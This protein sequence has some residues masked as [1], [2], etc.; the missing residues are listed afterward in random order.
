MGKT[1]KPEGSGL[2]EEQEST[3][4]EG[5]H[6]TEALR[7]IP[8][9]QGKGKGS[10]TILSLIDERESDHCGQGA[11]LLEAA[12]RGTLLG[13]VGLSEWQLGCGG[14]DSEAGVYK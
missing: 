13:A 12:L 2:E 6:S 11:H 5:L 7:S 14:Q 9:P 3:V 8:G 1:G 4:V 10:R